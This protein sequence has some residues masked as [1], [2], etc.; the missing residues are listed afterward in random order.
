M[1]GAAKLGKGL[2]ALMEEDYSGVSSSATSSSSHE[3]T[4]SKNQIRDINPLE[5]R[6]GK[7][8]PRR[9]FSELELGELAASIAKNGIMQPI[10]V[11][12]VVEGKESYEIIAGERRWRAAKRIG[13]DTVPAI[14][15]EMDDKQALELALVENV[16]RADLSPLEEA[17]GYQRLIDEFSYTQEQLSGIVGKSR[18]HIANLLRLQS[19]PEGIKKMLDDGDLSMGHAR[20]VMTAEDPL[21]LAKTVVLKGLNVRQAEQLAKKSALGEASKTAS[22]K[23]RTPQ[24]MAP[25]Q[26]SE[27]IIVLEKTLSD[28]LGVKVQIADQGNQ[29]GDVILHYSSLQELDSILRRLGDNF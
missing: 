2:S 9:Q 1:A 19:L 22:T 28:T 15:R 18:S 12:P 13:L 17:E 6:P 4:P 29:Q 5:I 23:S 20:A 10:V 7:Y 25:I 14:V 11:R 27:D 3:V 24:T 16:Q 21:T 8:Q 26:K